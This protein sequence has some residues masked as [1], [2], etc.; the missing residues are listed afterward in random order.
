MIKAGLLCDILLFGNVTMG[1]KKRLQMQTL[2]SRYFQGSGNA[3][4]N[5]EP[6]K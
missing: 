6:M 5:I 4:T 3:K 1:I 2:F